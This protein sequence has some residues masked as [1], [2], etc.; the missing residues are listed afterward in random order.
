MEKVEEYAPGGSG[1]SEG[2]RS[3]FTLLEPSAGC[4]YGIA[5][6]NFIDRSCVVL[7]E[8]GQRLDALFFQPVVVQ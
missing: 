1:M 8:S 2:P 3:G 4:Y 7:V 5:L 6:V